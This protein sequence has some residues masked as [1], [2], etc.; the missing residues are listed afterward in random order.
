MGWRK[1]PC[2][3]LRIT[4]ELEA[5]HFLSLNLESSHDTWGSPLSPMG[6]DALLGEP[7]FGFLGVVV[8]TMVT[9]IRFQGLPVPGSG[10]SSAGGFRL[11]A[12]ERQG[13]H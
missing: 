4:A 2:T 3:G 1:G 11:S 12:E 8:G 5:G 10:A 7:A 9:A 6:R 13:C